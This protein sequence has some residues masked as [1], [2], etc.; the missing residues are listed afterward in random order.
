MITGL[1][2]STLVDIEAE[3]IRVWREIVRY[4]RVERVCILSLSVIAIVCSVA[5][6]FMK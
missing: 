5:A 1:L 4:R 2:N 3:H 6:L